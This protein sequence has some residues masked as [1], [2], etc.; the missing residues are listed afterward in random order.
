VSGRNVEHAGS[1]QQTENLLGALSLAMT[2]RMQ[3]GATSAGRQAFTAATALSALHHFLEEPTI[4]L[5]R[6]VLGLTSSGTVRLVDR[7]EAAGYVRRGPGVDRRATAISLTAS[8]RRAAERVTE[9]RRAV[10]HDGLAALSEDER[11]QLG[12]LAGRMLAAMVR[13]PGAT[14]WICRLCDIEACGR[15]Q[16]EC[17]VATASGY[18]PEAPI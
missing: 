3:A 18:T 10:L 2:D 5:L 9:A 7:L 15:P 13:P 1:D 4:D 12:D 8:G 17:P 14:Q 16:G 11:R 6:Q